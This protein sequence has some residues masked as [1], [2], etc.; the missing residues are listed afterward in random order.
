MV[1]FVDGRGWCLGGGAGGFGVNGWYDGEEVLVFVVVGFSGGDGFVEG[2]EDG[3]VVRA[4]GEF[5]DH[6]GE[7]EGLL[8]STLGALGVE[9]REEENVLP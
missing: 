6:V 5:G 1:V 9:R 8:V 7:V 4:E 3:W 2:V